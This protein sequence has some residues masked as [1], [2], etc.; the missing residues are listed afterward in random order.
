MLYT[1][2]LMLPLGTMSPEPVW[3]EPAPAPQEEKEETKDAEKPQA[4]VEKITPSE[5]IAALKSA[6]K[7]K[8]FA[9]LEATLKSVGRVKDKGVVKEIAKSLKHKQPTVV[10][11]AIEGLRWNEAPEALDALLK[12][13][14]DKKVMADL[15]AAVALTYA[16][17]Q[18]ADKKALNA[19]KDGF[20]VTTRGDFELIKAKAHALGRIRTKESVEA[21]ID[22]VNSGVRPRTERKMQAE[23]LLALQVLTGQDPGNQVSDWMDWWYDAKG[24]LKIS[25]EEWPL[26]NGRAQRQWD[27]LWEDPEARSR[28]SARGRNGETRGGTSEDSDEDSGPPQRE[29]GSSEGRGSSSATY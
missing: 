26:P 4:E 13:A 24:S 21:L 11:V 2:L 29:D 17:G 5:A 19:L 25:S 22:Y 27:R 23:P 10:L 1:L 28:A 8:D 3:Q 12:A 6:A 18:K 16:L 7:E 14:K 20:Q 15:K 9:V